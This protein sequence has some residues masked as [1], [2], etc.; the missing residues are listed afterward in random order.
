MKTKALTL[1]EKVALI[2]FATPN[3]YFYS[4]IES[5]SF[6]EKKKEIEKQFSEIE[7][8][9][10]L[11]EVFNDTETFRKE[12]KVLEHGFAAI[13]GSNWDKML[14]SFRGQEYVIND[15]NHTIEKYNGRNGF[16]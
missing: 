14:V 8:V 3:L 9:D 11:L 12:M 7:N 10:D 16:I 6:T 2:D 1:S 15:R 5:M 4:Y 13:A